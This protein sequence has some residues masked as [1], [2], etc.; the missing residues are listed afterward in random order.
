MVKSITPKG[1]GTTSGTSVKKP[2]TPVKK[3]RPSQFFENMKG[4][5]EMDAHDFNARL[6]DLLPTPA[7]SVPPRSARSVGKERKPNNVRKNIAGSVAF[8]TGS[9]SA[10]LPF[11]SLMAP[12]P[13]GE[14]LITI[15]G[16]IISLQSGRHD[17]TS[18]VKPRVSTD[19]RSRSGNKNCGL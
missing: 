19:R 17:V 12:A 7:K 11:S 5:L 14:K 6:K 1:A 18:V 8:Q 10:S 16:Y 15:G 4:D 3:P 2:K 13:V 9:V